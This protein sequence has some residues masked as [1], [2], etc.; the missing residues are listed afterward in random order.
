[1]V[2]SARADRL[3]SDLDPI[4]YRIDQGVDVVKSISAGIDLHRAISF[5]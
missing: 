4:I 3:R 5:V 2:A 1:M